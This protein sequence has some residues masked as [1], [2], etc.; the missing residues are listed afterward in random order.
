MKS[1]TVLVL[2]V[3]KEVGEW[4]AIETD[5]DCKTIASRVE[6]EG[7]SFLMIVLP[8][9]A[10]SFERCLED[11][12]MD[13]N[14]FS[15]TW[16]IRGGAPVFL[17]GFLD[18]VFDSATGGIRDDASIDAIRGI[19]QVCLMTAKVNLDCSDDRTA[20][21][22]DAYI[23]TD[24]QVGDFTTSYSDV[25]RHRFEYMASRLWGNLLSRI[26]YRIARGDVLPRHGSGSTAN[27]VI[28][29]Q[30]YTVNEWTDRLERVFPW[31]E[32]AAA[33]W[34]QY[35]D[36][37]TY[38][39]P[40]Q[41]LPVKVISV[42]KTLTTPRI[43]AMEPSYMMF[44]QQGLLE[45]MT[46]ETER[47]DRSNSIISSR[48]Q[49][50]NRHLAQVG[51]RTKEYAT[52]DLS[53]ASD[54]VSQWHVD[55]LLARAPHFREALY[56]CRSSKALVSG[57]VITLSKFASMGSAVTF[58]LEALVFSTIVFLGIEDSRGRH[59][60]Q[61]EINSFMGHVRV[62]GDDIIIPTDTA[63]SVME[64][65]AHYGLVVNT[66]KSFING[67]FRE[68]CGGE[69]FDGIPV[70][71][72]RVRH[73]LPKHRR[74]SER[75]AS[76]SALRNLLAKAGFEKVVKSLDDVLLHL[77]DGHYP[78]ID[79]PDVDDDIKH[80][81]SAENR[82]LLSGSSRAGVIGRSDWTGR[83]TVSRMCRKLHRGQVRGFVLHSP[84]PYNSVDGY[85]ALLKFF[86]KRSADPLEK[87]HLTFSGRP[88]SVHL[89]LR[90][91][92]VS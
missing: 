25:D 73:P 80:S 66:S 24:K 33:S 29:N 35:Q 74:E 48:S 89:K 47:Y 70:G 26:D 5:R 57:R 61:K 18:L 72:V 69:Y 67:R 36:E 13:P 10:K 62:Y 31:L 20:K 22:F 58:P 50:P 2:S 23:S 7:E 88:K 52:L 9:F 84:I 60:S 21:A 12:R 76:L 54:R 59:L 34:S 27:S 64:A 79:L 53:E 77:L 86:L 81:L 45:L 41:E 15:P 4:C 37:I 17:R 8:T 40:E 44:M 3:L 87:D 38:L 39:S 85:G 75:V 28:G 91:A 71:I 42:P 55:A 1:L 78:W 63:P 14:H 19:R 68:S 90:W 65:L 11:G 56:A 16:R 46:E 32:N 82:H 49:M 92:Y 6:H 30:K 51:S 83:R 43:I